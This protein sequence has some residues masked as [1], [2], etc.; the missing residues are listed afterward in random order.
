MVGVLTNSN[1]A[2]ETGVTFNTNYVLSPPPLPVN[3]QLLGKDEDPNW[4]CQKDMPFKEFRKATQKTQFHFPRKG[5]AKQNLGDEWIRRSSGE[6]WTNTSIGY[7]ADTW[8]MPV[9]SFIHSADPYSFEDVESQKDNPRP[10]KF[11]YPTLLLNLD[12]K[13]SLPEEGVEW[14]FTRVEA[15]QIRNGRMDLEVIIMDDGREIVALSH[16]VAF[17][18]GSER[19]IA[20]RR[21][22]ESKI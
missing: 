14:L 7:V 11:W 1:L 17:A 4:A 18:V 13:K 12:I 20:D 15:K 10:A 3:L 5:Q 6:K 9:E 16:H 2:T 21:K 19:N 8:P 22:V